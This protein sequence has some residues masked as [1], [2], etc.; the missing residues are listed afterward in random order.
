MKIHPLKFANGEA[1]ELRQL[2]NGDYLC[3]IC[4]WAWGDSPPVFPPSDT[5]PVS[6]WAFGDVCE[7]GVEMGVDII[8]APD[9]AVGFVALLFKE[10]RTAWLDRVIWNP[11]A[12]AQL[13]N[14]LGL[15]EETVRNQAEYSRRMRALWRAV[16]SG[17]Q[18]TVARL[19]DEDP[20]LLHEESGISMPL[21]FAVHN[22]QLAIVRY[23][24][25]RGASV[26]LPDFC[27][28]SL[29]DIAIKYRRDDIADYLRSLGV[30]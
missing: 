27:P 11:D 4:G 16:C 24:V 26:H 15:S 28:Q 6:G 19:L 23:L 13:Q 30:Q 17:D 12:L 25:D 8:D 14:N 1:G 18:T 21:H 9:T 7:C 5:H 2:D 3:P 10:L 29:L 22:G 20:T